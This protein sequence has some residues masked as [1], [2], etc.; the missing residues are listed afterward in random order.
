MASPSATG[1]HARANPH[2]ARADFVP[3]RDALVLAVLLNAPVEPEGFTAA[4][5]RPDVAVDARGRV[6]QVQAADFAALAD[7]AA[8]TTRLPETG[9]FLNAWRVQHDRTSQQIDRL[10]VPTS[11][12]GLKETSV[13]GWHPDKKKLKDAV[14]DYEEL[15]SVLHELAGYVQEAREG[16]QRGQ[17]ENKALIEK[18]K[19]LVDETTN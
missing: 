14:A 5:F 19:A 15:P 4:L 2:P 13:Q 17:E 9:S 3:T 18:I 1:W 7:L 11:D 12:G 10:F 6:L 8:Q 16:F